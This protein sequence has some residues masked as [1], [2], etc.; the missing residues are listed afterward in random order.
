MR[1]VDVNWNPTN[2]Q[3]RQFAV[4]WPIALPLAGWLWGAGSADQCLLF[5]SGAAIALAGWL[6]PPTARPA[7]LALSVAGAP[8]GM[9]VGELALLL[10]YFAVFVP[11]GLSFRLAKRDALQRR[12]NREAKTYWQPKKRPVCVASYYRQS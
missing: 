1:L 4:V 9:V 7:F 10:I 11:I 3:L 12:L 8:I 6:Y 2:R 5:A